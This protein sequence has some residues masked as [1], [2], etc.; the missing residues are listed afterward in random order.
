MNST[1][2]L[3]GGGSRRCARDRDA[4]RGLAKQR[5]QIEGAAEADEPKCE[6]NPDQLIH[7]SA[8]ACRGE[9]TMLVVA[10]GDRDATPL[11]YQL[12]FARRCSGRAAQE[13]ERRWRH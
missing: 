6:R 4:R 8:L 5:Q 13:R 7:R 1:A 11:V 12:S 2:C 3:T 9:L 10:L